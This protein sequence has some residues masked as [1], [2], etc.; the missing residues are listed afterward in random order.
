MANK[1][2]KNGEVLGFQ[3]LHRLPK[4]SDLE[5]QRTYL[6]TKKK[7][8]IRGRRAFAA[9]VGE[10]PNEQRAASVEGTILERIVYR[11]LLYLLGPPG[12]GSWDYKYGVRNVRIFKGGYELDFLVYRPRMTAIEVQGARWH[13]PEVKY[14]DVARALA[15]LADG[16][17]YEEI[18]EWEIW[19]GDEY[20]DFRLRQMLG[21]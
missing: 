10:D 15:V 6:R 18:L 4:A 7:P 3:P 1:V 12:A 14:R 9:H 21:L 20:L 11:R 17:N 13:G 16:Y 2:R 5:Q 8:A 19:A